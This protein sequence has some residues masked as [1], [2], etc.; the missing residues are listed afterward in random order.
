MNKPFQIIYHANCTDGLA[1]AACVYEGLRRRDVALST[2]ETRPAQYGDPCPA[3]EGAS[4]YI[5]DFS[6]SPDQ[7]RQLAARNLQVQ[8]Y[9]H[10]K[11]AIAAYESVTLPDNVR[12]TFDVTRSG[13]A[14]AWQ[15]FTPAA[16]ENNII[17]A[18]EDRDLW[19]FALP[20]SRDLVS[21]LTIVEPQT[22]A[23]YRDLIFSPF[24]ETVVQTL[25]R[26]GSAVNAYRRQ[27]VRMCKERSM[28]MKIAGY[29]APAV[30]VPVEYVGSELG[31]DLAHGEPFAAMFYLRDA[32]TVVV[33]LRSDDNGVDVSEIA[34][35]HGGGGHKHA[36]AFTRRVDPADPEV[37]QCEQ[38]I[39][40][41]TYALH[42]EWLAQFYG[43]RTA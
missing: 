14:L 30:N 32:D 34:K 38:P 39:D 6:F 37:G 27:L 42:P 18:V 5:V 19:R 10:H 2:I 40:W 21:G 7:L 35:Q 36:A 15:A 17:K 13:A 26:D 8:M 31:Q 3:I 9:D 43:R 12:V 28:R 22:P 11:T 33:S 41:L 20:Y 1:A 16:E 25:I 4:I 29:N 24:I 23:H